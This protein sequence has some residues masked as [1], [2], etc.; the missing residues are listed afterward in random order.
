VKLIVD[1]EKKSLRILE[2]ERSIFRGEYGADKLELYINRTLENEYPTITA[3][4][5][6]GR[7]IGAYSTDSAYSS[8]T[9]D[10]VNYT[11]ASF[12]LSKENGFTLSE[13]KMQ[14][15]IWMNSNGKKEAIGNVL[16]NVINTT[17]FDDGDII[18][19]GDVEGTLVNY[20][21]EL[22]NLG[23]QV[24]TF[25][26]RLNNVE[27]NKV[28]TSQ[29]SLAVNP[30]TIPIRD[31]SGSINVATTSNPSSA[32]NNDTLQKNYLTPINN[33][34]VNLQ[35]NKLDKTTTSNILYGVDGY[36]KQQNYKFSY[37]ALGYTIPNRDD[38][39]QLKVPETPKDDAHATSRKYVDDNI[40]AVNSR[41][42]NVETNKLDK[43]TT[44]NILYG[45]DRYGKQ[46]N[47]ELDSGMMIS[48]TIPKRENNGQLV[49]PLSPINDK[50]ATS[51]SYV[52]TKIANLINGAPTALDTLKEL[53]D[54]FANNKSVVETLNN[55]I[56]NKVDKDIILEIEDE[57]EPIYISNN[58][59]P[60]TKTVDVM[61]K[62]TEVTLNNKID[63]LDI[64]VDANEVKQIVKTMTITSDE[65]FEPDD[66]TIPTTKTVA[67]MIGEKL[68]DI[69]T[70]LEAI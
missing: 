9:I 20:K 55:A 64:G 28:N 18:I 54:E 24:N 37:E 60:T 35:N 4:L 3:L 42:T 22:E 12:T 1:L 27:T 57:K 46:T 26:G 5:S 65:A 7:K 49:V 63:N 56:G 2:N 10:G 13:G 52:D 61:I 69:Q 43:T 50:H 66:N 36:G 21:V 51:K 59:V 41:L 32:V 67:N 6:N 39:G 38:A 31:N 17:A 45:V 33:N 29:V 14:I 70:L 25:N 23:N 15:T 68:G 48:G 47:F 53:A 30:N 34:I 11:I 19:S 40:K 58:S 16:L 44:S 8:E 62:R